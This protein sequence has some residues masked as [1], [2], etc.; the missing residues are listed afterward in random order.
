MEIE[1]QHTHTKMAHGRGDGWENGVQQPVCLSPKGLT[2]RAG[3][4]AAALLAPCTWS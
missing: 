1:L 4:K 3:D 2:E